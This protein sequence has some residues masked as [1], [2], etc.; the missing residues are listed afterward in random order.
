MTNFGY[1]RGAFVSSLPAS[2]EPLDVQL[3]NWA[4]RILLLSIIFYGLLI[5]GRWVLH[6]PLFT[7][8]TERV[9]VQVDFGVSDSGERFLLTLTKQLVEWVFEREIIRSVL[10]DNHFL[11]LNLQDIRAK[12]EDISFVRKAYVRRAFPN[13]MFVK[14]D[15]HQPVAWWGKGESSVLVNKY[16]EIFDLVSENTPV[17]HRGGISK[18]EKIIFSIID[19]NIPHLVGR[20]EYVTEILQMYNHLQPLLASLHSPIHTLERTEYGRWRVMLNSGTRLEL[21]RDEEQEGN[22]M[23]Q[24][25]HQLINT[26]PKI[27]HQGDIKLQNIEYIDLRYPSGYVLQL[28]DTSDQKTR[29]KAHK[30]SQTTAQ[31]KSVQIFPVN[32]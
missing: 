7:I 12:I 14:V 9:E 11:L 29:E 3:M 32:Q 30:N 8:D 26:L 22:A 16:G 27:L 28:R 20:P 10:K 25:I 23:M 15:V 5:G 21:G 1:Q 31:R 24:K 19:G 18:I 6:H 2:H 17:N 4:A 13:G